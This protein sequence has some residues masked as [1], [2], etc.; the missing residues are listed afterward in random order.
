VRW[1]DYDLENRVQEDHRRL[2]SGNFIYLR[3]FRELAE[4]DVLGHEV[5]TWHAQNFPEPY[6]PVRGSIP[7]DVDTFHHEATLLPN[8]NF[9]VLSS[10]IR[11]VDDF[12]TSDSDPDAPTETARVIGTVIVEFSP[13]GAIVKRIALLDLLDPR[14]IAR[15]SLGTWTIYGP[16][17]RDWAHANAVVYDESDDSY[18]VSLRHQD[19]IVKVNRSRETLS[20]IFGTPAN[21]DEPW[22]SLLLSPVGDLTW[23]FHQ[24]AVELTADGLGLYDNG[25]YR[26]AAFEPPLD[27]EYS[28]VARYA[29]NDEDL[30]VRQLWEYGPETGEDSVFSALMGDADWQPVTGNVLITNSVLYTEKFGGSPYGQ[31]LEVTP[32]GQRVFQLDVGDPTDSGSAIHAI[33]RAQRLEDIRR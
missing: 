9:L 23:P 14:R 7:V 33:Y 17:A 29:P 13:R 24:H 30:T 10:E 12:P 11:M 26:A 2:S 27:G 3:D 15:D 20:W 21:W 28:R 22:A 6:Q 25:N 19:A 4:I 16:D 8:G 32:D 1:Y 18:Y 5:R 31:L